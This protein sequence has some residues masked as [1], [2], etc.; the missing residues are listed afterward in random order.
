MSAATDSVLTSD[1]ARAVAAGGQSDCPKIRKGFSE[2][3]ARVWVLKGAGGRLQGRRA[4]DEAEEVAGEEPSED[5]R[6][7]RGG[8]VRLVPGTR[9]KRVST[10]PAP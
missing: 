3:G 8:Q 7:G 2:E 5:Q 4:W 9:E 6:V 10:P 1:V